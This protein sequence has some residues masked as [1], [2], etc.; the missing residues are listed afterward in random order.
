MYTFFKISKAIG[1]WKK[2][3]FFTFRFLIFETGNKFGHR[4]ILAIPFNHFLDQDRQRHPRQ[5]N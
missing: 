4:G 2:N 1:G 3:F 5:I